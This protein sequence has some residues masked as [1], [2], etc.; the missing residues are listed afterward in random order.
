M[1]TTSKT[2]RTIAAGITG[3][4]ALGG[5]AFATTEALASTDHNGFSCQTLYTTPAGP[6]AYTSYNDVTGY[7]NPIYGDY[8]AYNACLN[9]ATTTHPKPKPAILGKPRI[10]GVAKVGHRLT[11]KLPRFRALPRGAKKA[12]TWRVAGKQVHRGLTLKLKPRWAG[13]KVT[14]RVTV[15]WTTKVG[16]KA[17]HHRLAATSTPVK[18]HR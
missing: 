7:A 13:K 8:S 4:V 16:K 5:V 15:T 3:A 6:N 10:K 14:D 12:I 2:R 1:A 9:P 18:I 17:V 11:A